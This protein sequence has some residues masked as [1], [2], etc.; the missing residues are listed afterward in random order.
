MVTQDDFELPSATTSGEA[1]KREV[2]EI[3][4]LLCERD[5]PIIESLIQVLVSNG[6]LTLEQVKRSLGE[7]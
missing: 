2:R 4:C 7:G 1:E 3:F 5:E 6:T